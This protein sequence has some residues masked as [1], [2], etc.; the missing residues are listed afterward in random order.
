MQL[1]IRGLY[2]GISRGRSDVSLSCPGGKEQTESIAR[3]GGDRGYRAGN[4]VR[5]LRWRG[6][7]GL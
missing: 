2:R 4:W 5:G 1:T 6:R 3:S 7:C